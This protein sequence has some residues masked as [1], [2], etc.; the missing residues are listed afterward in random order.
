MATF[1]QFLPPPPTT[2]KKDDAPEITGGVRRPEGDPL[3]E[4]DWRSKF[5]T[6]MVSQVEKWADQLGVG[7]FELDS[8]VRS[9]MDPALNFITRSVFMQNR[10]NTIVNLGDGVLGQQDG[11]EWR[12]ETPQDWKQIWDAGIFFFSGKLGVDLENIGAS[13]GRGSGSRGPSA[14][15]IRNSFDEDELTDAVQSL[16][17]S[18]LFE[19]TSQARSI[20]KNYINAVVAGGGQKEV[21]FKTFVVNRMKKTPRWNLIYRNKPEGVDPLQYSQKYAQMAEAAIGGGAGNKKLLGS[22]A[23]GGAAL[24]ASQDAFAGRLQRTDAQR[25]SQGFIN[26]LEETVRG[27]SQVLRG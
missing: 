16:W 25:N 27:V 5:R 12:P 18:H 13:R 9:Q 20:A 7:K 6:D 23:A 11:G 24:G 15:D 26:G 10:T 14:A 21:D 1:G 8:Y 22:L 3:S 2:E 19:D 4:F 17:G